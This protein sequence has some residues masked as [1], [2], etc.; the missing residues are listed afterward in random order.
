M[1]DAYRCSVVYDA[2]KLLGQIH[3]LPDPIDNQC[4]Q[5]CCGG[6]GAPGHRVHIERRSGDFTKNCRSGRG[7][8][9]IPEKHRMTPVHHPWHDEP[10]DIGENCFKRL[11]CFRRLSGKRSQN[12]ARFFVRRNFQRSQILS[13]IRNPIR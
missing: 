2:A 12:R 6:T 4:F 7:P 3:P 1:H 10:I 8:T 9:E 11:A 13:E 5:F